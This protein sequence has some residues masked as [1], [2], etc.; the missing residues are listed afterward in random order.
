MAFT[1]TRLTRLKSGAFSAR[2]G[3]PKD[4][5]EK[6]RKHFGGGWEER[7]YAKPGTP[8][9]EA[10]TALSEW[11]A[12]I[13]ARIT[14]VRAGAAGQQRSLTPREALALVGE[15]YLWFVKQHE[16]DPGPTAY[17]D[18]LEEEIRQE[19]LL[20][21]PEWFAKSYSA[22]PAPDW[23]WTED[24]EVRVAIRPLIADRARTAKFLISRGLALTAEAHDR[25]LDAVKTEYIAALYLLMVVATI[26]AIPG[27]K[28]F[29]NSL[30]LR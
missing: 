4:V 23:S 29:R 30:Q 18:E 20:H 22:D 13:E 21:A 25:F 12:Q 5:R 14:T 9:G 11:L 2:K 19:W 24:E 16:D 1:M 3:I 17:W 8:L 15:W 7:F 6:Y 28:L 10:K 26:R 27:L